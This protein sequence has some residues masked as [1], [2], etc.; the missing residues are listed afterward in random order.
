MC[1]CDNNFTSFPMLLKVV[2]PLLGQDRPLLA[3]VDA[4]WVGLPSQLLNWTNSHVKAPCVI[5][6]GELQNV[7]LFNACGLDVVTK[8]FRYV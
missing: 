2:S 3:Q 6:K 1:V 5:S 7:W 4:I 8:V